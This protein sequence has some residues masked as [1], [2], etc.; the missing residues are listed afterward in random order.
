MA[1]FMLEMGSLM[2]SHD[3]LGA[4]L[5]GDAT[6]AAGGPL[7][8]NPMLLQEDEMHNKSGGGGTGCL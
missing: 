1:S 3:G 6:N 4:A 5:F 7:P 8:E 2:D